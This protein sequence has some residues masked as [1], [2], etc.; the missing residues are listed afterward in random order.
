MKDFISFLDPDIQNLFSTKA[1]TQLEN[2]I[3]EIEAFP[4]NVY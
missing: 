3:N 1:Q 4:S 2:H